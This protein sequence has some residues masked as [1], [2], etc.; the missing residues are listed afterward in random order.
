[1]PKLLFVLCKKLIPG[2][3]LS[4]SWSQVRIYLKPVILIESQPKG[5]DLGKNYSVYSRH[6]GNSEH[7]NHQ[8]KQI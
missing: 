7:G 3:I 8:V 4:F 6:D 5:I 2:N 1:M